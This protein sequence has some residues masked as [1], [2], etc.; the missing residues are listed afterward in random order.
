MDRFKHFGLHHTLNPLPQ[1]H[2]PTL[3]PQAICPS[4][5]LLAGIISHLCD[6]P[7]ITIIS[8]G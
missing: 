6:L 1:A 2:H 8:L 7:G 5:E 3:N 4:L